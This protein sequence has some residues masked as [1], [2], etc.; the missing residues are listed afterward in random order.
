MAYAAFCGCILTPSL[1]LCTGAIMRGEGS[2]LFTK[3]ISLERWA[4]IFDHSV[5]AA[6]HDT[7]ELLVTIAAHPDLRNIVVTQGMGDHCMLTSE[8]PLTDTCSGV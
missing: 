4:T 5:V 7:G 8:R 6:T 3:R 2:A 1:N